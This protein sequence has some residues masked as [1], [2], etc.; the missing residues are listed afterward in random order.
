MKRSDRKR[1]HNT[2]TS[3]RVTNGVNIIIHTFIHSSGQNPIDSNRKCYLF[4][5]NNPD[6]CLAHR[7]NLSHTSRFQK[8]GCRCTSSTVK[9]HGLC[10]IKE[11]NQSKIWS[12]SIRFIKRF[13][14]FFWFRL[15]FK[16][17]RHLTTQCY[18]YSHKA[19]KRSKIDE[20]CKKTS[21]K[22]QM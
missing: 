10:L 2:H 9:L 21:N 12:K 8:H 14:R 20:I 11:Y 5:P 6:I 22:C 17:A 16:V 18:Y 19:H 4:L 3:C 15:F 1:Q 13:N 7:H